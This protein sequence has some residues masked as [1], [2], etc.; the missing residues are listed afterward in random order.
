PANIQITFDSS[1]VTGWWSGTATVT[2]IGG[3][4][5]NNL[6]V[7]E[8]PMDGWSTTNTC[9]TSL[10]ANQSCTISVTFDGNCGR[11]STLMVNVAY[12]GGNAGIGEATVAGLLA[13]R[14]VAAVHM[15]CRD[16]QRAEE[17]AKRIAKRVG[18][19]PEIALADLAR[20]REVLRI[21]RELAAS[22]PRIDRLIL[23]AGGGGRTPAEQLTAA[24]MRAAFD[25]NVMGVAHFVEA[26]LPALLRQGAARHEVGAGQGGHIVTIGSIAGFRGLPHAAAYGAAKAA[27]INYTESL[28][29]DLAPRGIAVTLAAPGFIVSRDTRKK[30]SKPM[31]MALEPA[32]DLLEA[33]ILARRSYV[34]FPARLAWI[35]RLLRLLPATLYDPL[36]RALDRR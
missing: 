16:P 2:N 6:S 5:A 27:L 36:I 11:N 35:A 34:S 3:Q 30:R 24:E 25:L 18:R 28:R 33:A 1:P 15:I 14:D 12:D 20:P 21:S 26:A 9:S 7:T 13:R 4:T 29:L 8:S 32:A 17:A 22:L 23:N 31:A 10:G 19:R